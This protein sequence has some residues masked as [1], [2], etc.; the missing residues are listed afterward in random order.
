MTIVDEIAGQPRPERMRRKAE[1]YATRVGNQ[2]F[3]QGRWSI[4]TGLASLLN[5]SGVWVLDVQDVRVTRD[6][7]SVAVE[8]HQRFVNPPLLE[9]DPAGTIIRTVTDREG[10]TTD[11][12]FSVVNPM[13]LLLN[14][15]KEQVR[16]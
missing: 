14:S 11:Q 15:L 5:V 16:P 9:P 2:S 13:R 6:G 3:T 1:H 12:T 7:I 8:A 4:T 10:V